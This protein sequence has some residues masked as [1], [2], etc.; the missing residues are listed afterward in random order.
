MDHFPVVS[1]LNRLRGRSAAEFG[2]RG[3][4]AVLARLERI[5]WLFGG[6]S[7]VGVSSKIAYRS[8][9]VFASLDPATGGPAAIAQAFA[10]SDPEWASSVRAQRRD[11]KRGHVSLLGYH[12]LP[13]GDPPRWHRE[14]VSG[15]EAPRCHWSR[16]DHLDTSLV[17]DHKVLWELNRHQ[18]L[19]APA[20]CWL[21]DQ[22]QGTFELVRRH[23][24]SW[25]AENPP[26]MG[27]NWVSS[28]EIAYRAITWCWLL[29]LL[30]EAPWMDLR[31]RLVASLEA[32]GRHVERYLS[33]Y[34]SPN[35]HLTGEAL[36]LFYLGTV[37]EGSRY[38]S[39][40]RAK[41]AAILDEW[42]DR[43]VL[44]DGVYFEQA[45][46][47]HR[48]TTEIYL[49]YALLA[50]STGWSVS[51][52]V[53]DRLG[54]LLDVLRSLASAEGQIP[55]LGDDDGG[56]LLPLDQR[57]PDD[58]SALLLTGAVFLERPE[59]APPAASP[60]MA[61]WL[62]GLEATRR[63][64]E[65][66]QASPAW[67]DV[68]FGHGGLAILRDGWTSEDAASVIDAGPHGALSCGHSHAD[69]M[70]MTLT[71]SGA[72]LFIDR[73]TLTYTG[74]KRNEYRST[75]S[76]NTL[77]IDEESSVTPGMPF[78]WLNVPP[79]ASGAV[80]CSGD[81]TGFSGLAFGH[82]DGPRPSRHERQVLHLRA[83]PWVVL[84]RGERPGAGRGTVRWQLAPGLQGES[85]DER[86]AVIYTKK[87]AVLATV[88][89]PISWGLWVTS[90][91]ASPRLGSEIA[92]QVL[93]IEVAN[94]LTAL[95]VIVPGQARDFTAV[96]ATTHGPPNP[97]C[98]WRDDTGHH[99][100]TLSSLSDDD[101]GLQFL[102]D[103]CWKIDCVPAAFDPTL[104]REVIAV[105]RMRGIRMG[106]SEG[107]VTT[108]SDII[109]KMAVFEKVNE[110]W[111]NRRVWEP[112]SAH[113]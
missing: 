107:C 55:L 71:L 91:G 98:A 56:L 80:Y 6:T 84:D 65:G 42:L 10:S 38:A 100:V 8:H 97:S 28:L 22:D 24:E 2:A 74:P 19:L 34:F 104:A 31:S 29:W 54:R 103:L 9:S 27:V 85:I 30:R 39:R 37:L 32:H 12:D 112:R 57:A 109:G 13:I 79:R 59:L 113:D 40:W 78:K 47:Y 102:G 101:G 105:S 76:H 83:G 86:S 1:I 72:P 48:Y 96:P 81:I 108:P 67:R 111:M 70:A 82:T 11:L 90:R 52:A 66:A 64:T 35:T 44:P 46:Q 26:G 50:G 68:S 58:A 43:Q 51:P 75:R 77:E 21:L 88:F 94:S 62:C 14:A 73:G 87:G 69:A 18:Y 17:G 15:R 89:A 16:I 60:G 63:L 33:T 41:G 53:R 25:L 49:H 61:Y 20:M 3:R 4:Q 95:T 36:G 93:E 7:A 23:L 110:Q 99:V 106:I 45:S 92:A 5:Q